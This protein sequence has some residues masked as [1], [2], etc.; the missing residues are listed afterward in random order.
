MYREPNIKNID[1]DINKEIL[2]ESTIDVFNQKGISQTDKILYGDEVKA[3]DP[4]KLASLINTYV[5]DKV[6]SRDAAAYMKNAKAN[7]EIDRVNN[8]YQKSFFKINR[9]L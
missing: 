5:F 9:R 7:G 6:K 1:S 3:I 8:E 2:P 4:T